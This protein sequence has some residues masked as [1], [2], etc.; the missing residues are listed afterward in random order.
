MLL[1]YD[2][3]DTIGDEE[4]DY[5][6]EAGPESDTDSDL[7]SFVGGSDDSDVEEEEAEVQVGYAEKRSRLWVH[8]KVALHKGLIRWMKKTDECRQSFRAGPDGCFGPWSM[9]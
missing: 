8:H 5:K 2:S 7:D 6:D 3:L 1:Q 4:D 9:I